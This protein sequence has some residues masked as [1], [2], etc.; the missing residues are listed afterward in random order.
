MRPGWITELSTGKAGGG[1]FSSKGPGL[2]PSERRT[3]QFAP[4]S[5][6]W[7]AHE[8]MDLRVHTAVVSPEAGEA[9]EMRRTLTGPKDEGD[10]PWIE[11]AGC[12][13][14]SKIIPCD[15]APAR[16]EHNFL[17]VGNREPPRPL[18]E[19]RRTNLFLSPEARFNVALRADIG[20]R[21]NSGK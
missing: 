13:A 1:M 9:A 10:V 17:F 11:C 15:V 16:P 21:T 6:L 14:S 2:C 3:P 18:G 4:S 8:A 19:R 12:R 5:V 20:R 7:S